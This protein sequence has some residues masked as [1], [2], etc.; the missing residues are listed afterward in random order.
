MIVILITLT[1]R[2]SDRQQT[3]VFEN[4]P[5]RG[6]LNDDCLF[7]NEGNQIEYDG[8]PI[9]RYHSYENTILNTI[10]EQLA[11]SGEPDR[12]ELSQWLQTITTSTDDHPSPWQ[13]PR[14]MV[15]LK[16]TMEDRSNVC[17]I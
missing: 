8:G 2:C 16:A 15:V 7:V 4:F 9:F 13:G 14:T 3:V 11:T 1:V 6:R 5:V 17:S 12:A 10:I